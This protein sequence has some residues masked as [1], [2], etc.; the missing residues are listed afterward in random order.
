MLALLLF[1]NLLCHLG[2]NADITLSTV[3]EGAW[4]PCGRFR[5]LRYALR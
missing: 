4:H 1:D 3:R 2:E 5:V